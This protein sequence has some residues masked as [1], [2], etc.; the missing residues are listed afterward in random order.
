MS[1]HGPQRPNTP[2]LRQPDSL[3]LTGA[4]TNIGLRLPSE[5]CQ[6]YF[7]GT[8]LPARHSNIHRPSVR[9]GQHVHHIFAHSTS[10]HHCVRHPR[11]EGRLR[12][13]LHQLSLCQGRRIEYTGAKQ[14]GGRV[15]GIDRV[16]SRCRGNHDAAILCQPGKATLT[17]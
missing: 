1:T 16:A 4:T 6:I 12:L 2:H 15:F 13:L 9:T 7:T 10:I 5:N 14:S 8:S 17:V 3:S 11:S